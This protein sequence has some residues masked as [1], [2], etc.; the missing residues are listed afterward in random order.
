MTDE[1]LRGDLAD[2][3]PAFTITKVD[4]PRT[5]DGTT[6]VE[7]TFT[8]P[9]Y[10]TGDGGPGT[11]LNLGPDHLPERNGTRAVPFVCTVPEDAAE[12]SRAGLYGHG[13]LGEGAQANSSYVRA[14]AA[15]HD[16]TFC[17]VDYIGMADEDLPA[18]ATILQDL[19]RFAILPDRNQQGLLNF[20]IL[21]RLLTSP[22]GLV[23]HAAFQHGDGSPAVDGSDL[24]YY[25]LSQGG[26]MGGALVAVNPDLTRGVLGVPGMNYST[27]L[28]RSVDFD[29]FFGL[30]AA[31]YPSA[32]DRMLMLSV[33]QM[34]WDRGEGNG[35]ANHMT[36]DPLPGNTAEGGPPPAGLRRPPGHPVRSRRAGPHLRRRHQRSAPRGRPGARRDPACGA[37]TASPPGPTPARRSSTGTAG[38][39]RRRTPTSRPGR[40]TTGRTPTATPGATL[41]PACRSASSS[42]PAD[43]WSTPAP[44]PPAWS[45]SCSPTPDRTGGPPPGGLTGPARPRRSR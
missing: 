23:T 8:G 32:L 37:S 16:M 30:L 14:L 44:A 11:R 19:S 17:G 2:D 15:E 21:G 9:S 7:G 27:L 31:G 28:H 25:G 1:T 4:P 34:L 29:P 35:Y 13:L 6:R 18:V 39:P 38:R 22:E 36:A 12:P 3:V 43:R 45:T 41:T 33:I 40:R 10:L 42:A 5:D 20:M 26:I 24:T